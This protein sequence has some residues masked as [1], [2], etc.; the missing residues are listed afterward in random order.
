M[1]I[2]RIIYDSRYYGFTHT[3]GSMG[4]AFGKPQRTWT[5][6]RTRQPCA[7]R[8][9]GPGRA[10]ETN[11]AG[12]AACGRRVSDGVDGGRDRGESALAVGGLNPPPFLNGP[13]C[14]APTPQCHSSAALGSR[15]RPCLGAQPAH[16]Q[17]ASGSFPEALRLWGGWGPSSAW[18][19]QLY[20]RGAG[21][22]QKRQ[23]RHGCDAQGC[24]HA[25]RPRA[26]WMADSRASASREFSR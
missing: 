25:S 26:A 9:T 24:G 22:R 13:G 7:R 4:K 8:R 2:Y 10:K 18:P 12:G 20:D 21:L 16:A 6:A 5:K 15:P 11:P 23:E 3:M 1:Y 17:R 14:S 19:E